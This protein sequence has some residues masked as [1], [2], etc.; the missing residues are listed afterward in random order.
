MIQTNCIRINIFIFHCNASSCS[1]N[2]RVYSFCILKKNQQKKV[3]YYNFK[4][5]VS[6]YI[7]TN[8]CHMKV[9]FHIFSLNIQVVVGCNLVKNCFL[10]EKVDIILMFSYFHYDFSESKISIFSPVLWYYRLRK[11]AKQTKKV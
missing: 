5:S 2:G 3:H 1:K 8:F 11:K 6:E 10:S 7:I 4:F 9:F